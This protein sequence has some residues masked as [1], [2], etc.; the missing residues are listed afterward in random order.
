MRHTLR[1]VLVVAALFVA[2]LGSA[3][4]QAE[5]LTARGVVELH[6]GRYADALQ[7]FEQALQVDAQDSR[8]RYYRAL[9]F[10]RMGDFQAAAVDL[11][12]VVNTQP[13]SAQ[14][15]LDLGVT[16]VQSGKY[17][18]ALPL[19]EGAQQNPE[20][21]AIASLFLGIAHLALGH[22]E[23]ARAQFDRAAVGDPARA[24]T[25]HYY[26][27]LI[28]FAERDW[29]EADRHLQTVISKNPDSAVAHQAAALLPHVRANARAA[30]QVYAEVGFQYD[31]NVVLAPADD[32]VKAGYGI[33]DRADGRAVITAGGR[34]SPVRTQSVQLTLGY[35]LYQS[36]H[37]DLPDFNL[38]DHRPS[39]VLTFTTARARFG[40]LGRYDFYLLSTDSFL[41]EV[42]AQPWVDILEGRC[43]S[44][45]LF[46]RMRRRDFLKQPFSGLV[47][48][49]NHMAGVRQMVPIGTAGNYA[50]VGYQYDYD[51]PINARGDA[52]G[53]DGHEFDAGIGWRLPWKTFADVGYAYRH[54]EYARQSRGREDDE[55]IVTVA[56]THPLG[57]HV[58]LR[59]AYLADLNDSNDTRFEY[60]RHIV[61]LTA[62]LRF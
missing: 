8:A 38:Q 27:G 56:A 39:A 28:S 54:E 19:L 18:D 58:S 49:F 57:E 37:F 48:A 44:T 12:S 32:A 5:R 33:S 45:Q 21:E 13:E 31:S 2:R 20:S 52:F 53:Y 42:V 15:R 10:G 1:F 61:S 30:M 6:A 14:A 55:H 17:E 34:Y 11:G 24:A 43:G 7:L 23:R 9:T 59:L 16:L 25:A 22:S 35:E 36:L 51:D 4:E 40:M 29:D 46:Y 60:T 3:A 50:S 41:Q 62:A 26:L 47:D